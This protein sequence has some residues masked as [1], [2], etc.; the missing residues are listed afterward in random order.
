[1]R[2][3][4]E[5]IMV[6]YFIL[7]GLLGFL[8]TLLLLHVCAA[9]LGLFSSCLLQLFLICRLVLPKISQRLVLPSDVFSVRRERLLNVVELKEETV[10][11]QVILRGCEI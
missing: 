11:N 6:T 9:C 10:Q 3:T 4:P 8:D 5:H 2:Y 1:M 7:N